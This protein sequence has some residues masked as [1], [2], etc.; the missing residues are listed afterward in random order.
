[1]CL[2]IIDSFHVCSWATKI[3]TERTACALY[4]VTLNV[5]ERHNLV[6]NNCW[7]L[8]EASLYRNTRNISESTNIPRKKYFV[9]RSRKEGLRRDREEKKDLEERKRD[10][11]CRILF[12]LW[13]KGPFPCMFMSYQDLH[14]KDSMC[15]VYDD[16]DGDQS[17][18][19]PGPRRSALSDLSVLLWQAVCTG[20]II[21]LT[22]AS[23][24]TFLL[25]S[26][27]LSHLYV[28][29]VCQAR[30]CNMTLHAAL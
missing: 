26:M 21:Y 13:C 5:I 6:E 1:M 4:I 8:G 3:S 24:V 10:I 11:C 25:P 30:I 16:G 9:T 29:W 15:A 20:G 23:Q 27:L 28:V 18:E 22:A 17:I 7:R 2:W 12:S 19:G 14:R